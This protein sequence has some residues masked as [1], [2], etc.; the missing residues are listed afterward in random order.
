MGLQAAPFLRLLVF[1]ALLG[2]ALV[3]TRLADG[4]GGVRRLLSRVL[5]WRFSV[6]RWTVILL[7]IPAFVVALAAASGT[8]RNHGAAGPPRWDCTYSKR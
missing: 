7:G 8:L 3:V 5:I 1:V 4:P 2:S 6:G